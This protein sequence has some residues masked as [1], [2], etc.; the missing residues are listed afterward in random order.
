MIKD[1]VRVKES[2]AAGLS[3]FDYDPNHDVAQAYL[4]LAQEVDHA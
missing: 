4:R 1:S 2:P 3:I